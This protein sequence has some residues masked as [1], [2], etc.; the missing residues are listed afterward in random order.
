M[1]VSKPDLAPFQEA[2]KSVY[3]E[4]ESVLG[5]DLIEKIQAAAK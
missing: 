4:W 1:K 2:T 5:K 3:A